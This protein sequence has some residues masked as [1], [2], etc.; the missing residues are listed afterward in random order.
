MFVLFHLLLVLNKFHVEGTLNDLKRVRKATQLQ[1]KENQGSRR[2]A[3]LRKDFIVDRYQI[4]EARASGA[5]TI[6]L[7]V[8]ILG[9]NQLIDL[10][11]FSR[12]LGVF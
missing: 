11:T 1:I 7:M 6:L 2:P 5:D 9:V 10:L 3:I 4:L 12:E 8:S